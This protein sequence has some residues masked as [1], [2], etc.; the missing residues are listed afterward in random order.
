MFPMV[1]MVYA[2]SINFNRPDGAILR[3]PVGFLR[4]Y[5]RLQSIHSSCFEPSARLRCKPHSRRQ[6]RLMGLTLIG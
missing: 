5:D 6:L 2:K 1:Q 4:L 3:L